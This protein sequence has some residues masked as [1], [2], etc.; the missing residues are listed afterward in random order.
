MNKS[1]DKKK[2]EESVKSPEITDKEIEQLRD[3]L[4]TFPQKRIG[5]K[6]IAPF[7]LYLASINVIRITEEGGIVVQDPAGY[8][9]LSKINAKVELLDYYKHQ[10]YLNTF[11]E[12][13][14]KH[15]N[16]ILEMRKGLLQKMKV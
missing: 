13:R 6:L 15:I 10:D 5:K 14:T 2:K 7:H 8:T 11:P 12:E 16:K 1:W 9:R 4:Q 3:N